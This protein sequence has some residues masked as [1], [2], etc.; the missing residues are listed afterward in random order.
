MSYQHF[1]SDTGSSPFTI[2]SPTGANGS[3][4]LG[5]TPPNNRPQPPGTNGMNS[6]SP[7]IPAGNAAWIQPG[8]RGRRVAP[9]SGLLA[10]WSERAT[11]EHRETEQI[12][13]AR[14]L[15]GLR[16]PPRFSFA[17]QFSYNNPKGTFTRHVAPSMREALPSLQRPGSN[18]VTPPPEASAWLTEPAGPDTQGAP[19][20]PLPRSNVLVTPVQHDW[21]SAQRDS[22]SESL[23]EP[24][25]T[26]GIAEHNHG[27]PDEDACSWPPSGSSWAS[28]LVQ[29]GGDDVE[30]PGRRLACSSSTSYRL[31]VS[32]RRETG[33]GRAAALRLDASPVY[34]HTPETSPVHLRTI[35]PRAGGQARGDGLPVSHHRQQSRLWDGLVGPVVGD[36]QRQTFIVEGDCHISLPSLNEEIL[37]AMPF[38][39]IKGNL[40][41]ATTLQRKRKRDNGPREDEGDSDG[42]YEGDVEGGRDRSAKRR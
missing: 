26:W 30:E 4:R 1:F 28:T 41:I 23:C 3:P 13:R 16:S 32:G 17:G 7:G 8:P 40:Y 20:T 10:I 39:H 36:P 35:S 38:V 31:P 9:A 12:G 22:T 25:N 18:I 11:R 19:S 14:P 6:A 34:G 29:V 33:G 42:G 21:R 37:R 15:T 2:P 24:A 5:A 27:S